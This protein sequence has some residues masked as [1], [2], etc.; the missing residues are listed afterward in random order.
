MQLNGGGAVK[1]AARCSQVCCLSWSYFIK[2]IFYEMVSRKDR[3]QS[4]FDEMSVGF[5]QKVSFRI[6]KLSPRWLFWGL[7][8]I[9]G[10]H[11]TEW[12]SVVKLKSGTLPPRV[13]GLEPSI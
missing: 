6:I 3:F 9:G 5:E 12:P 10:S 2:T 1:G 8:L 13:V 11:C 7:W 4:S